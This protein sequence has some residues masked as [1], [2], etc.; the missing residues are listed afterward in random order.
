MSSHCQ[1]RAEGISHRRTRQRCPPDK[2][3]RADLILGVAAGR[4]GGG[5]GECHRHLD[6]AV[7]AVGTDGDAD[8]GFAVIG[9]VVG[10]VRDAATV[11]GG[12]YLAHILGAGRELGCQNGWRL[13]QESGGR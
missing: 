12:R 5:A 1:W 13:T 10:E 9:V 3:L 2:R 4:G 6:G 8:N 11:R 7:V